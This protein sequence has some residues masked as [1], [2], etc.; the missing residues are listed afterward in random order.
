M[1]VFLVI[2]GTL[3]AAL[4]A[5]VGLGLMVDKNTAAS[6]RLMKQ[7]IGQIKESA[8]DTKDL[9]VQKIFSGALPDLDKKS[10]PA[11]PHY[12]SYVEGWLEPVTVIVQ[13]SYRAD[14]KLHDASCFYEAQKRTDGGEMNYFHP[15][16]FYVDQRPVAMDYLYFPSLQTS[17][18]DK[19]RFYFPVRADD[20]RHGI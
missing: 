10:D 2:F 17:F 1:K 14:G 16:S 3:C 9:T 12:R 8:P 6:S 13:F 20:V 19:Y 7:C 11:S 4:A 18:I 5:F 15:K